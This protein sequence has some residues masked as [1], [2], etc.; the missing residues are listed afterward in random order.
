ME[1]KID[2]VHRLVEVVYGSCAVALKNMLV[3]VV[4]SSKKDDRYLRSLF[5]LLDH[6]R[7]FESVHS[8]HSNV[9]NEQCEWLGDQRQK[10]LIG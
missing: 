9:Q 1:R 6:L 8:R 3:F 7:E 10:R 2:C 5:S 4:I